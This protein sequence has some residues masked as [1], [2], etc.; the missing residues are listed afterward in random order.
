M[1]IHPSRP[2]A[3]IRITATNIGKQ[4]RCIDSLLHG[5][6]SDERRGWKRRLKILQPSHRR[7]LRNHAS[8]TKP[9]LFTR[10]CAYQPSR[11]K[12]QAHHRPP[13][14]I[15]SSR[16]R[17]P[18]APRAVHGDTDPHRASSVSIQESRSENTGRHTCGNAGRSEEVGSTDC[19]EQFPSFRNMRDDAQ[20]SWRCGR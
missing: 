19:H 9:S 1:H 6:L 16:Q 12:R 15:A 13:I 17:D 7:Q 2:K 4:R 11:C 18:S 5:T 20:R 8:G 3:A 14:P 10:F